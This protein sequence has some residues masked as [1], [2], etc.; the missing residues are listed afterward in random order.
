MP[1][2]H[3]INIPEPSLGQALRRDLGTETQSPGP[4]GLL[5]VSQSRQENRCQ[6][7]G[8]CDG[9]ETEGLRDPRGCVS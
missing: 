2:T 5:A 4:R 8:F 3:P 1:L 7:R 6:V 9:R